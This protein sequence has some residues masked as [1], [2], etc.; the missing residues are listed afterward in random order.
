MI[1]QPD[2]EIILSVFLFSN[3]EDFFTDYTASTDEEKAV[4]TAAA[5]SFSMSGIRKAK[6]E[7]ERSSSKVSLKTHTIAATMRIER[8]YS[9]V[10]EE[11]SPLSSDAKQ[12]LTDQ[13]Y[14]GFFMACGPNYVR[15]IRRAQEVTAIFKFNTSSRENARQYASS[16]ARTST[17]TRSSGQSKF[18]AASSSLKITILGYGMGL[19]QEGSETFVATTLEEYNEVMTFAFKT[20][21]RIEGHTHVGMIYGMEVVPWVHN[22]AFQVAAKLG[23]EDATIPMPRSLIP[24]AYP[25]NSATSPT[26]ANTVSQRALFQCK[27]ASYLMDKF[28][29]CCE[30]EQMYDFTNS[31]YR[32]IDNADELTDVC[33]PLQI[34]DRNLLKDNMSNNG[35][36]VSRLGAAMRNKLNQLGVLEMCIGSVN[37]IPEKFIHNILKPKATEY[38][39]VVSVDITLLELKLGVDPFGDYTLMKHMGRELDEWIEMFYSPCM[40]ALFGT[41]VGTLPDVDV[42]FFATYPWHS[43]QECMQLTCLVP[44]MRWDRQNGGCTT[45]ILFGKDSAQDYGTNASAS[46]NCA[47][48]AEQNIDATEKCKHDQTELNSFSTKTKACWDDLPIA[49]IAHFIDHYCMPETTIYEIT[50]TTARNNLTAKYNSCRPSR[51]RRLSSKDEITH[52]PPAESHYVGDEFD[53][54]LERN[55][56]E[57]GSR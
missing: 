26:W 47:K 40:A 6:S 5:K 56:M 21:T 29:Y 24:R 32:T 14:V 20:M 22:T 52:V 3:F 35:E 46:A 9:S 53:M 39:P 55:M 7:S 19:S 15:G 12:L 8:Y 13:D 54:N 4:S 41:N 17:R 1:L 48:D 50:D 10:R 51:R 11:I 33:R 43:H 44:N 49:N 36:F 37:A 30:A 45:G 34:L 23:D 25:I 27:S 31:A 38:S 2:K 57:S 18:K 42:A 16:V 28:G